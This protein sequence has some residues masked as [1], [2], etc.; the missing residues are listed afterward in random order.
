[1]AFE[2][3]AKELESALNYEDNVK[4]MLPEMLEKYFANLIN[5]DN[6]TKN[7]IIEHIKSHRTAS[8]P[9]VQIDNRGGLKCFR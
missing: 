7:S 2:I 6:I 9:L 1:M 3:T 8:I 5:S 4:K